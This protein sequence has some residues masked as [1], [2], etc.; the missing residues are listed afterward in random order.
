MSIW[1]TPNSGNPRAFE[2]GTGV[3]EQDRIAEVAGIADEAGTVGCDPTAE[4]NG[5]D[6]S[7]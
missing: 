1:H 4:G 2:A 5:T 7:D 6:Y 3:V